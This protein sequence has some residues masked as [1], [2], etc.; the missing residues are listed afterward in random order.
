MASITLESAWTYRTPQVT[1]NYPAGTHEVSQEVAD[2]APITKDV[3]DG[4]TDQLAAGNAPRT[5]RNRE[6]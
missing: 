4:D 2:K 5:T 6:E 3:G 1:I